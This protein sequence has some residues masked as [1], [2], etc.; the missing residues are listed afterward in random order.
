[1]ESQTIKLDIT[2][3]SERLFM[4]VGIKSVTTDDI[5]RE[6]GISKK[7]LYQHFTNKEELVGAV[8]RQHLQREQKH[9]T[10]VCLE[11]KDALDEIIRI[12]TT[13]TSMVEE[14]SA[15]T[16]YD[17]QKYYRR[18]WE[19]MIREQDSFIMG[20]IIRNLQRGMRETLYRQD[21]SLDIT[22]KIYSKASYLIVE[23][24]ADMHSTQD[25]RQL[26]YALHDYHIHAVATPAGLEKWAAY[27]KEQG[28]P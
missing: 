3:R 15:S 12:G 21:I 11:A 1:M 22:A 9:I 6:L 20:C 18:Y 13:I 10:S 16:L 28:R 23:E 19:Y 25:R 5:A 8:L 17:L 14:V 7:T 27:K 24:L 2:D 4:K 26:I